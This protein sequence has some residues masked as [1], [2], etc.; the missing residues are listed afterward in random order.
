MTSTFN[1]AKTQYLDSFDASIKDVDFFALLVKGNWIC[2]KLLGS[3]SQDKDG[4]AI[5]VHSS[6]HQ[7]GS[8]G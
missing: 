3:K 6:H 1:E 2:W 8:K 5:M 7:Q 4:N